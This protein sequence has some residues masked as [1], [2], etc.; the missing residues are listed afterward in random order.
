MAVPAPDIRSFKGFLTELNARPEY[1]RPPLVDEYMNALTGIPHVEQDGLAH[2]LYRG[3][4]ESV[5]IPGDANGWNPAAYPMKRVA[6]TNLWHYTHAF[7]LNARLDYKFVINGRDWILDPLNCH[8]IEGGFGLNSELRMPRYLPPQEVEFHP[9]IPHGTIRE[10]TLHSSILGNSRAIAVYTPPAYDRT[11]ASFPVAVFHDG[12]DFLSLGHANNIIDFLIARKRIAPLI[13]V[14]VPPIDR[15]VEYAGAQMA[16]F[17]AFI[18]DELLRFVDRNFRTKRRAIDRATIG[19]S[20]GG[21]I[22]L[23]SGL[24]YPETFGNIAAL[25]SNVT[26]AVFNG[27]ENSPR[28]NLKFYLDI[29]TYDIAQ[30]IPMVKRFIELVRSKGYPYLFRRYHEGHSW[31]NWRAHLGRALRYFF[32]P[33][34][35]DFYERGPLQD[36]AEIEQSIPPPVADIPVPASNG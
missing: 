28:L 34:E 25:S 36:D 1:D 4:P 15:N 11:E 27:Y 8:K 7:E 14:F 10:Q 24:S 3:D 2:F 6:G 26:A 33:R 21:N 17:Y 32:P 35:I 22:A 19:A 20:N 13:G 9:E 29:G 18:V 16:P 31:G 30:L 12:F 23:W 5:S